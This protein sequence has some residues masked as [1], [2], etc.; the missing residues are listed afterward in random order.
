MKF[1][2]LTN[3]F[4]KNQK[5]LKTPQSIILKKIKEVAQ[6][7]NF[8]VY[9]NITV[10]HYAQHIFIPIL[11]L[12]TNNS[13]HTF[14]LNDYTYK[15]LN[16]QSLIKEM[17]ENAFDETLEARRPHNFIEQKLK[18]MLQEDTIAVSNHLVMENLN[19]EDYEHLS[20]ALKELM[21]FDEILF[22]DSLNEDILARIKETSS[23][24]VF[25]KTALMSS[26]LSQYSVVDSL[27]MRH[28]ATPEQINFIDAPFAA[29]E[30]LCGENGTGRTY[31]LLLKVI[32]QKLRNKDL[33]IVII[34]PSTLACDLL[35]K[36][37]LSIIDSAMLEV[38]I[39]SIDVITPIELL[40]RHL[41]AINKKIIGD[42][43]YLSSILMQKTFHIADTV[44]CDDS[45]HMS[46]EFLKYLR[47][48]QKKANLLT[49]SYMY[50]FTSHYT[51]TKNFKKE[52]REFTFIQ[53][54]PHAK[55][56]TLISSLLK[57]HHAKDILVL[58][59]A[60][61]REKLYDD[62]EHFIDDGVALADSSKKLLQQEL[63]SILLTT[64]EDIIP[65]ESR[66][67]ILLDLC[68]V[69]TEQLEDAIALCDGKI[70]VLYQNEC[71]KITLLRS[72]I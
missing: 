23:R 18:E 27:D 52:S 20:T 1:S 16:K 47:H 58:S 69:S 6:E 50:A 43:K 29:N 2:S 38:D 8:S 65:F 19:I 40:H 34:K 72:L 22:N 57:E 35:R 70:Y 55:V 46:N 39:A 30:Y 53:T 59:S 68:F 10:Y 61:T 24:N 9:E 36:K 31:S 3:L 11:I 42:E 28:L 44:I 62:L 17:V 21:P 13:I 67:L 51:F 5:T 63:N 33:K 41:H 37:L 26:I 48:I 54:N 60:L 56:L 49:I 71:E 15:E 4:K 14:E 64:Y 66:F 7:N 12:D 25:S 45:E 32:L